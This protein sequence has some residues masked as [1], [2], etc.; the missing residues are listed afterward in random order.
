MPDTLMTSFD[1]RE[2]VAENFKTVGIQDSKL[3]DFVASILHGLT[4]SQLATFTDR[5]IKVSGSP[6]PTSFNFYE[7]RNGKSKNGR[8]QSFIKLSIPVGRLR[9]E[10]EGTYTYPKK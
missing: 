9:F 7:K 10:L 5:G 8:N 2:W 6:R 4:V 3:I 1:T